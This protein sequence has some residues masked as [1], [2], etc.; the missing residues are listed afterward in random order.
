MIDKRD[1]TERFREYIKQ[2]D[3]NNPKIEY[4]AGHTFRVASDCWTLADELRCSEEQRDFMWC[5][6]LLHDIGRFPQITEFGTFQDGQS[7]DH[8]DLGVKMLKEGYMEQFFPSGVP[9]GWWD[10]LLKAVGNH[11]KLALEERLSSEECF[12]CNILRDADKV[13]IFYGAVVRPFRSFHECTEEEVQQSEITDRVFQCMM[14]GR[15]IPF[16]VMQ[17]KADYFMRLYAMYFDIT[18]PVTVRLIESRGF[19][20]RLLDFS[21]TD[22]ENQRKFAEVKEKIRQ[23]QKSKMRFFEKR[24]L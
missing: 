15:L 6:G 22:A 17:T 10:K 16:S 8:A 13:D 14:E 12:Y 5:C 19:F 18:F 21:F 3:G 24:G 7:L 1:M 23:F 20:D 4:K 11:N 9:D 2:F